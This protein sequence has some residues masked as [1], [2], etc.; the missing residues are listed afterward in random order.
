MGGYGEHP[1][2]LHNPGIVSVEREQPSQKPN[3]ASIR[4]DFEASV[5][6][7]DFHAQKSLATLQHNVRLMARS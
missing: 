1:A 3:V 2:V 6:L 4:Y 7:P 5:V